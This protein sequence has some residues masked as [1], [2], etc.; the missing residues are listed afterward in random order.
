MKKHSVF[1]QYGITSLPIL[2][3]ALDEKRAGPSDIRKFLKAAG[4][5]LEQ[6]KLLARRNELSL[7]NRGVSRR[8]RMTLSR[9]FDLG[10]RAYRAYS[11]AIEL[12]AAQKGKPSPGALKM[13]RNHFE[14]GHR[15]EQHRLRARSEIQGFLCDTLA[16]AA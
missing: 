2:L 7:P 15:F 3:Q 9:Y 10:Y 6:K 4:E 5:D 8:E 16:S 13:I 1:S 12:L 14:T 11:R